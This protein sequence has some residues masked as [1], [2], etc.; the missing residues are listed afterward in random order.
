M[1]PIACDMIC[2]F[3]NVECSFLE[4]IGK[5]SYNIFLIQMLWYAFGSGVIGTIINNRCL[6]LVIKLIICLLGGAIFYYVETPI[7]K[8]ITVLAYKVLDKYM[9]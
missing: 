2:K 7:T 5:C 8:R 3:S 4:T 9:K 6:H 1:I